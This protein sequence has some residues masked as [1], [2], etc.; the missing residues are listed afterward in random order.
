[1]ADRIEQLR[2]MLEQDPADAFC[3]YALGMEY[4][5]QQQPGPAVAHLEQSLQS[6]PD[7]PYAHFHMA[8]CLAGMGE[9]ARAVAAVDAGL[10]VASA[11]GDTSAAAELAA[12]RDEL[13]A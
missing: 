3:L 7:Q 5:A 12:L 9:Q 1:M 10:E 2:R 6:D 11:T 13:G 8:R 4:A